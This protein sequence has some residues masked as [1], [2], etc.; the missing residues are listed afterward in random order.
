M[1][2][3]TPVF[4]LKRRARLLAREAKIPLHEALDRVARREGFQSWSHLSASPSGHRPASA[5]LARLSPGDLVLLGAR[6][7]HGK[8]LLGLQLAIEAARTGRPGFF[9]TLEYN[10]ADVRDRL[11]SF[12]IDPK[13]IEGPFTLD[14]SDDICA[15]HI[16]ERLS[17]AP[18]NS[19]AVIDYLQLLDQRRRN[20]ELSVQIRALKDVTSA[21]GSIIVAISQIDRA[22][23]LQAKSLPA[24]ADV[25][26]PNPLD[27]TLFTKSCFLHDGEASLEAI[28]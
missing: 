14:T 20:P 11:A 4:R 27:L 23:D 1:R 10:E 26:L 12:G 3:S 19:V 9:F 6:P 18:K 24:L 2:F 13:A 17:M 8:T 28:A 22:F 15:D 7:G 21:L 25:R 16:I 5:L